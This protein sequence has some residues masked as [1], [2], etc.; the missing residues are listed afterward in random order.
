M[1]RAI[2]A[3]REMAERNVMPL[4]GDR[5][6]HIAIV[7]ACD[8]AVLTETV[9]GFWDSR[10]GPIFTRLAATSRTVRSWRMA[11]AEHETIRD[12]VAARDAAA[13]RAGHARAHGQVPPRFSASWR[14]A[15]AT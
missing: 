1:T 10:K 5:A 15:K 7:E 11:I 13:A 9:Q 12:A 6:F 2:E 4:E 3:M 14:R 8:N